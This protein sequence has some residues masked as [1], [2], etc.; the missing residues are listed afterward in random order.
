M[1]PERAAA[2][3][4]QLKRFQEQNLHDSRRELYLSGEITDVLERNFGVHME[5]YFD[6]ERCFSESKERIFRYMDNERERRRQS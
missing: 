2:L 5:E 3:P 6:E 4:E 1:D